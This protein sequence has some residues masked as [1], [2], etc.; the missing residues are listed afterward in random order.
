M[1]A[2]EGR[3]NDIMKR[4]NKYP[5]K[6]NQTVETHTVTPTVTPVPAAADG[7]ND[8]SENH[9]NNTGDAAAADS[10]QTTENT[11][12]GTEEGKKV[13]WKMLETKTYLLIKTVPVN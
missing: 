2:K 5:P 4:I 10:T 1:K 8:D 13:W 12:A 9:E 3:T 6:E 7:H 11:D